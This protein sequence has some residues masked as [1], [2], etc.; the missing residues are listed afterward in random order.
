M[1][2]QDLYRLSGGNQILAAVPVQ[3][4][5]WERHHATCRTAWFII[6][7][8]MAV[9]DVSGPR[10]GFGRL[11]GDR[12]GVRGIIR[13]YVFHLP[14]H[15]LS[16][17]LHMCSGRDAEDTPDRLALPNTL[18]PPDFSCTDWSKSNMAAIKG[19][20]Q[21]KRGMKERTCTF[22]ILYIYMFPCN[23]KHPLL[24]YTVVFP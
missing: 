3:I 12:V 22:T 24:P 20:W 5:R 11:S 4:Y 7:A 14:P 19:K 10:L 23:H 18:F 21:V 17:P 8:Y 9:L 13:C 15:R 1:N 16:S 6:K 2:S